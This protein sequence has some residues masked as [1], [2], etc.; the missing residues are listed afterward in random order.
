MNKIRLSFG[1]I[2]FSFILW[3]G[4][5]C[6]SLA[7]KSIIKF[8]KVS[9][10]EMEMTVYPKDTNAR[11]VVLADQG[12]STFI[13]TEDGGLQLQTKIE[14]RIKIINQQGMDWA[15]GEIFLYHSGNSKEEVTYLK[16]FTYNLV[17]GKIEKTKISADAKFEEEI[18]DFLVAQKFTFP[19]VKPGS[20]LEYSYTVTSDYPTPDPWL[21]QYDIPVVESQYT[22]E[23]PE[24]VQFKE[25]SRGYETFQRTVDQQNRT[26]TYAYSA[27]IDATTR[28]GRTSG[29]IGG[30][31]FLATIQTYHAKDIPAF[32]SEPYMNSEDNYTTAI[33]F[34]LMSYTPKFGLHKNYSNTWES[35]RKTLMEAEKFGLQLKGNNFLDEDAA[36]IMAESKSDLAKATRAYELIKSRM[37]WNKIIRMFVKD[38]LRTAY[39]DGVGNSAEINLLLVSLLRKV[40]LDANPVV[41][42]TRANGMLM[43]GWVGID[44]FNYVVAGVKLFNK[45][46]LLDATDK[47]CPFNLLPSRCINGQGRII[48]ETFTD[49]VDLNPA[50][51][52]E[53]TIYSVAAIS[54]EGELKGSVTDMH[55]GYAAYE[56]RDGI[57]KESS[58]DDFKSKFEQSKKGVEISELEITDKDSIHKPLVLKYQADLTG[59]LT[60]AGDMIYFNPMVFGL[61]ESNPFKLENR[62]YP[63]DFIYPRV[64]KYIITI[65]IPEEYSVVEIPKSISFSLPEKTAVFTYSVGVIGNKLNLNCDF[66]INKSLFAYNEYP[67][68]KQF[69][70]N[71]VTKQA[72]QVVF[73]KNN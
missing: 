64:E 37:A 48:S 51:I 25:Q 43:P 13:Y 1:W 42:S 9:M 32:I 52:Y 11:A 49:W 56:I 66:K 38:N 39:K 2:I 27:K 40:G 26:F 68:L 19:D 14:R 45:T 15:D 8:G 28:E 36:K 65:E 18:N 22:F 12:Y 46:I 60:T 59:L 58:F 6:P 62:K 57:S 54:P 7:Q 55:K 63:V 35:V 24:F 44:Q 71:M 70:E 4:F 16:G 34:E 10:D 67:A 23:I 31:E 29:G 53:S 69:Y 21:F 17:N 30:W 72:E 41:L 5:F 20:V 61:T 47:N 50:Q 33:I 3:I 73:K